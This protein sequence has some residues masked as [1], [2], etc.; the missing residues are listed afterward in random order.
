M[1]TLYTRKWESDLWTVNSIVVW[2]LVSDGL[3][4]V[5]LNLLGFL[6]TTVYRLQITHNDARKKR[7]KWVAGLQEKLHCWLERS[8]YNGV[9]EDYNNLNNLSLPWNASQFGQHVGCKRKVAK[10]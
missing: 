7:I 9:E 2:M 5:F 4:W 6:N 3:F 1:F 8:E 10:A